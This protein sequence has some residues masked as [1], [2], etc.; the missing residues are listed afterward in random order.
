M[1]TKGTA[2]GHREGPASAALALADRLH[3]R[4]RRE[5]ARKRSQRLV[6]TGLTFA[7]EALAFLSLT[8]GS[9][10]RRRRRLAALAAAGVRE[11]FRRHALHQA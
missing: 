2:T 8:V 10:P 11:R 5:R 7:V 6:K 4:R 3:Q 1:L 9:S